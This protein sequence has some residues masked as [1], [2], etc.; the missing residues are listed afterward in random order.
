MTGPFIKLN[1]PFNREFATLERCR[2]ELRTKSTGTVY[3]FVM[4]GAYRIF[5]PEVFRVLK[6]DAI[7]WCDVYTRIGP[8]IDIVA[9]VRL[10]VYIIT[11]GATTTFYTEKPTSK[12]VMAAYDQAQRLGVPSIY[13]I[14][15]LEYHSSFQANTYDCYL[16]NTKVVHDVSLGDG[17]RSYIQF[18]WWNEPYEEVVESLR[19]YHEVLSSHQTTI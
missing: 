5:A 14:N 9:T 1:I 19:Q 4:K 7:D 6:P 2:G 13:D 18:S 8:H 11:N 3:P 17:Q 12:P 10:N 16:L 15:H